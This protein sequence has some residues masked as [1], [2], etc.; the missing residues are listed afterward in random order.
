VSVGKT[1]QRCNRVSDRP[2]SPARYVGKHRAGSDSEKLF[3]LS[4]N[5]K[6]GIP[7]SGTLLLSLASEK[8]E[9]FA[10]TNFGVGLSLLDL[11]IFCIM[12]L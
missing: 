3:P 10:V 6:G 4:R 12:L 5:M 9:E 7:Y 2:F 11:D 8:E 1:R